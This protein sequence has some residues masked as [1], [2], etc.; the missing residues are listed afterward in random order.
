VLWILDNS[1]TDGTFP[2]FPGYAAK[3]KPSCLESD[4]GFFGRPALRAARGE[5]I[6]GLAELLANTPPDRRDATKPWLLA[7]IDLQAIKAAGVTFAI[8]MLERVIEE[9]ARGNPEAAAAIRGEA[10]LS[11][12]IPEHLPSPKE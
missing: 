3:T 11:E 4:E 2:I 8:S 10:P 5:K 1:G 6:A 7:P 9:R 12:K